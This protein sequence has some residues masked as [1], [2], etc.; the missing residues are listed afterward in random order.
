M[1]DGASEEFEVLLRTGNVHG[2]CEGNGFAVVLGF[3]RNE[4]LTVLSDQGAPATQAG[5][6][7]F[8]WRSRPCWK[9]SAR[10]L[11]GGF[12]I[13]CIGARNTGKNMAC[14]RL[15]VVQPRSAFRFRH[16]AP[17]EILQFHHVPKIID[18]VRLRNFR[19]ILFIFALALQLP[20]CWYSPMV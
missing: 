6:P 1:F 3:G 2:S 10:R 19:E 4:R 17:Y 9:G 8:E 15:D 14:R 13:R 20:G 5:R 12:N 16:F 18:G 11:N 7:L